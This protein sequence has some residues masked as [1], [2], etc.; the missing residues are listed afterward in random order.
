MTNMKRNLKSKTSKNKKSLKTDEKN[1][2]EKEENS[3]ESIEMPD[4]DL[5]KFL[6]CGG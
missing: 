6:G 3:V 5:K 2:L 1:H 4:V